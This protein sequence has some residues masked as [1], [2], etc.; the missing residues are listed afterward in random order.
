[1]MKKRVIADLSIRTHG[2]NCLARRLKGSAMNVAV[3]ESC[4]LS[5]FRIGID[6]SQGRDELLPDHLC[7][8][9]SMELERRKPGTQ[10]AFTSSASFVVEHD[11]A[12][13][14]GSGGSRRDG[15]LR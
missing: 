8:R 12:A 9:Q 1:M 2:E 5:F 13:D 11:I 7:D 3:A 15:T 6:G 14:W 10:G 4:D